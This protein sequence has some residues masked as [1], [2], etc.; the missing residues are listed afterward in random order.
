MV[1]WY[2]L[3]WSSDVVSIVL[4][5]SSRAALEYAMRCDG[6]PKNTF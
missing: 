5:E 4:S 2:S 1:Q 3:F 6:G